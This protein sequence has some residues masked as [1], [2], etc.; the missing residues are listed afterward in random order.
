[1]SEVC[2]KTK[3]QPNKKIDRRKTCNDFRL[4]GGDGWGTNWRCEAQGEKEQNQNQHNTSLSLAFIF[5]GGWGGDIWFP[6]YCDS[7]EIILCLVWLYFF[8]SLPD[9]VIF[10]SFTCFYCSPP[11]H[12]KSILYLILFSYPKKTS[13]V[14][15]A[16]CCVSFSLAECV[17]CVWVCMCMSECVCVRMCVWENE[18]RHCKG[19]DGVTSPWSPRFDLQLSVDPLSAP[20]ADLLVES[21]GTCASSSKLE[22]LF[23]LWADKSRRRRRREL[24]LAHLTK[25]NWHGKECGSFVGGRGL[26][27][28]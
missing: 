27:V 28:S 7:I 16:V 10:F 13:A 25:C 21:G 2:K 5:F 15:V 23:K 18:I 8:S 3:T 14:N 26:N 11:L 1:M 22:G 6:S 20:P 4:I 9:L 17:V 24:H 19:C 12:S